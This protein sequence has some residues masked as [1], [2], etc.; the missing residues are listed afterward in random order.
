[1]KFLRYVTGVTVA[2]T[3]ALLVQHFLVYRI[4]ML[5]AVHQ[6]SAVPLYWWLCYLGPIVIVLLV[7][8]VKAKNFRCLALAA[9][10]LAAAASALGY[11]WA[12][13]FQPGF[14]EAYQSNIIVSFVKD[15]IFHAALFIAVMG[16][17]RSMRS[18]LGWLLAPLAGIVR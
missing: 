9:L 15:Y 3:V 13:F 14:V 5:P 11:Y 17:G 4:L 2:G 6:L 8:G 18:L 10:L 16:V 12:R 7:S 1:M